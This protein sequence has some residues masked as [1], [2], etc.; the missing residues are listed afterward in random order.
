VLS[1]GDL[2]I[3]AARNHDQVKDLEADNCK[4]IQLDVTDEFEVI[5]ARVKEAVNI[6][7]RVD[8]LVNNAGIGSAGI[9]EETGYAFTGGCNLRN[10][11]LSIY[12]QCPGIPEG[13]PS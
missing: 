10:V 7:G 1:R 4:T 13:V 5:Q 2:V 8:V 9:S 6:W 12:T 11:Q 3:A